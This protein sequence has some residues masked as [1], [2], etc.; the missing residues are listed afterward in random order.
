[1]EIRMYIFIVLLDDVMDDLATKMVYE[2]TT[3]RFGMLEH[4][5]IVHES[6]PAFFRGKVLYGMSAMNPGGFKKVHFMQ[7]KTRF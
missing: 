4:P 3:W 2:N 1:M 7:D 6:M 5:N